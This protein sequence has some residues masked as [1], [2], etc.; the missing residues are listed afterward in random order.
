M[1]P[2]PVRASSVFRDMALLSFEGYPDLDSV[3]C[4]RGQVL[5]AKREDIPLREGQILLAD[6]IGL[7]VIDKQD[8]RVYGHLSDIDF[9]PASAIYHV[10]TPKGEEV[11]IP[12]IPQFIKEVDETRGIFVELIP[13]FF[14]EI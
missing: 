5:Y 2:L 3:M 10:T 1:M 7:P 11:L 6:M 9:A 8:G 13:G 12:A 4:L 14:D